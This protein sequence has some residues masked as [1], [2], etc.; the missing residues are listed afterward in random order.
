MRIIFLSFRSQDQKISNNQI[1]DLLKQNNSE[2][3]EIQN[4]FNQKKKQFVTV[5]AKNNA[6]RMK[7]NRV[8]KKFVIHGNDGMNSSIDV[9]PSLPQPQSNFPSSGNV[10][11]SQLYLIKEL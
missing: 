1:R 9:I 5:I 6:N 11:E 3:V 8:I 4:Q 10:N 7:I 2:N